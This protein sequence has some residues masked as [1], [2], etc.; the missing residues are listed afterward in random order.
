V[1]P[2]QYLAEGTELTTLQGVDDAVFIDFSVAQPVLAGLDVGAKVAIAVG[3][4]SPTM[5]G[6]V[7]RA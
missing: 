3:E 6:E 1:H 4:S 7:G 2:G 5:Q